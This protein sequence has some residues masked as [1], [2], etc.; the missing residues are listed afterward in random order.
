MHKLQRPS[1]PPDCLQ[2]YQP[3]RN[4]WEEVTAT[5]KSAIW[6][7]LVKMQGY[8]CAYCESSLEEAGRHIEHFYQKA[9]HRFP[10][11][12]FDWDNLFGSCNRNESCGRQKDRTKHDPNNIIKPDFEDPEYYFQFLTDGRIIIRDDLT[13]NEYHKAKETLRVFNLNPNHG[14]LRNMRQELISTYRRQIEDIQALSHQ[15]S[16]SE[17]EQMLHQELAAI[18]GAPFETAIKQSLFPKS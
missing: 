12:T 5:D 3:G 4:R 11:K 18:S 2:Q 8:R 13:Q 15:F 16:K 7:D 6:A 1:P 14:P 17:I 9:Q 10:Q